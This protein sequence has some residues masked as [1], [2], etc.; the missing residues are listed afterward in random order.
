M[1][2]TIKLEKRSMKK[3]VLS[4]YLYISWDKKKEKY[5][6]RRLMAYIFEDRN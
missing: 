3:E 4:Y 6:R 5:V 1:G 2:S